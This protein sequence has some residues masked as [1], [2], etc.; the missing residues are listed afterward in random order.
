[1]LRTRTLEAV[2]ALA[3]AAFLLW[4]TRGLTFLQDEWDFIQYRLNWDAERLMW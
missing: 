1:M 4:A 2:A 3:L